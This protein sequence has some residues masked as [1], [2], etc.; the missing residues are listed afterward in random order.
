MKC[1]FSFD[2]EVHHKSILKKMDEIFQDLY[3]RALHHSVVTYKA[4]VPQPYWNVC[5]KQEKQ[6]VQI[7]LKESKIESKIWPQKK[8]TQAIMLVG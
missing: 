3:L 6:K 5:R 2:V 4:Y 8:K 7:W 1:F